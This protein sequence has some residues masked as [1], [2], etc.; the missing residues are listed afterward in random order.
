VLKM[1]MPKY[2]IVC[3]RQGKSW[4][5]SSPDLP[6]VFAVGCKSRTDARKAMTLA[7]RF[8]LDALRKAGEP[9]PASRHHVGIVSAPRK[10][11]GRRVA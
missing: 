8:H 9:L 7:I 3:E 1:H 4:A 6:K 10:S 2:R 5:A 11:N